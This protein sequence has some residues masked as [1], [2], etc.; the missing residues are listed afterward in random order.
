MI[1][2]CYLLSSIEK[3]SKF[4]I[5]YTTDP[6]RRLKEHNEPSTTKYTK[7]TLQN[8]PWRMVCYFDGF[9]SQ[10][11]AKS[12]EWRWQNPLK[13]KH[14]LKHFLRSTLPFLTKRKPDPVTSFR[15][16]TDQAFHILLGLCIYHFQKLQH[17]HNTLYIFHS[18]GLSCPIPTVAKQISSPDHIPKNTKST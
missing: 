17:L 15:G 10:T 5:G 18:H 1:Y 6:S 4:Y 7:A 9:K 14:E 8:R 12:F 11:E 13:S 16:T 3:P 2:G